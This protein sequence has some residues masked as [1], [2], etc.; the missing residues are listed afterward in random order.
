MA[1][2]MVTLYTELRQFFD[3]DDQ[4]R[5]DDSRE[6]VTATRRAI[7][8]TNNGMSVNI[9]HSILEGDLTVEA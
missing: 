9:R 4:D 7:G 8:S 2:A 3:I 6:K 1:M 5:I